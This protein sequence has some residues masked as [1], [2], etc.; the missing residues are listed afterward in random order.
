[1]ISR[2]QPE[3]ALLAAVLKQSIY[4]LKSKNKLI[5][6]DAEA[7]FLK[8]E[9]PHTVCSFNGICEALEVDPIKTREM[10]MQ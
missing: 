9:I 1:M 5:R 3:K 2:G 8:D 4:D 6:A 7:W 10:V